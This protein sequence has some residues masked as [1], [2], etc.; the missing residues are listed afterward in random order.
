MRTAIRVCAA[1]SNRS[2]TEDSLNYPDWLGW[3]V[4]ALRIFAHVA[5]D[6]FLA[7][8]KSQHVYETH[9][10]PVSLV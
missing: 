4:I 10:G 6:F 2:V 3:I 8:T 5:I 7:M 9:P 1:K